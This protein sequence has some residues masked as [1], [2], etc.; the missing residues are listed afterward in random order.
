MA[1]KFASVM[2]AK[3][4]DSRTASQSDQVGPL[5]HR[6]GVEFQCTNAWSN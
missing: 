3:S 4:G 5:S 1:R 2:A 6:N